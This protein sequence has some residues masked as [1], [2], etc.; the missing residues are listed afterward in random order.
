V[1]ANR[2]PE[3]IRTT[4][5]MGI[6]LKDLNSLNELVKAITLPCKDDPTYHYIED[7]RA[8]LV[9]VV[10]DFILTRIIDYFCI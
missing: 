6:P 7:N 3:K 1:L 8:R 4:K 10:Y 9:S 2:T 5:N